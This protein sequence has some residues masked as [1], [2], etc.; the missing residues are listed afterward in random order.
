[1][2]SN[3]LVLSMYV[4]EDQISKGNISPESRTQFYKKITEELIFKRRLM[5]KSN[6]P[7][8]YSSLKEQRE[9]ILGRIA[10]EHLIN[11]N[12]S[13][14]TLC[15]KN[16]IRIIREILNCDE[17]RANDVFNEIAKETGLITEERYQETFRFIHLTF[18]EFLAAFE[19][20]QGITLGWDELLKYHR[21]FFS[22]NIEGKLRLIEVIPFAVGLLSRV[23]REQALFDVAKLND[24]TL[25]S[26][27]FLETKLY[28]HKTWPAFITN[29]RKNILA[30]KQGDFNEKWLQDLHVFNVVVRDANLSAENM[31]IN[32]NIDLSEF[33]ESLLDQEKISLSQVLSSL[34]RQDAAAVFRLAEIGNINLLK[35]F[36]Y[37]I[38]QNCDQPPFLGLV[39]EKII[40][41]NSSNAEDWAA[42]L[43]EAALQKRLI[44]DVLDEMRYSEELY[45]KINEDDT[46]NIWYYKTLLPETFL[47]QCI[48]LAT[49]SKLDTTLTKG[50]NLLFK[51]KSPSE[52]PYRMLSANAILK[53]AFGIVLI[54]SFYTSLSNMSLDFFITKN[55]SW[56]SC[57]CGIVYISTCIVISYRFNILNMYRSAINRDII[58]DQLPDE[59][60]YRVF[61]MMV[62]SL[63]SLIRIDKKEKETLEALVKLRG[64]S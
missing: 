45:N 15:W 5:Q 61:S 13:G 22:M 55:Y 2:C 32:Q 30:Y 23:K 12:E 20:A 54:L 63:Y 52:N 46:Y 4:A 60:I 62:I 16:A 57:I 47:T 9:R 49:K 58:T 38:I 11:I 33:Y 24:S 43:S 64:K 25:M 40:E 17:L 56:F 39:K 29:S 44:S 42:L 35:D 36:P 50:L 10:Y 37:I 27:C 8:S 6:I 14:N 48:T 3:P 53:I 28:N 41:N 19:V 1:M 51:I 21:K 59:L 18:C 31:G 34:A 26:R 7:G